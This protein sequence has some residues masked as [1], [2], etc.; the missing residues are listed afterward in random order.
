MAINLMPIELQTLVDNVMKHYSELFQMKPNAAN[1]DVFYLISAMC[2]TT[3]E[4]F[5]LWIGGFCPSQLLKV[6]PIVVFGALLSQY[7][8]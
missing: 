3:A 1:A 8:L 5:F 2:K 6:M 7:Q 4:C